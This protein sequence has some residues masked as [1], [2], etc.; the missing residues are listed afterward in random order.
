MYVSGNNK[1]FLGSSMLVASSSAG[2]SEVVDLARE[3]GVLPEEVL[4]TAP[5]KV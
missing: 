5:L 2:V 1:Y 3:G 4:T